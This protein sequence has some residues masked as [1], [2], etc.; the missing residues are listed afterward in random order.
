[1]P[2]QFANISKVNGTGDDLELP[3]YGLEIVLA[4]T[5]GFSIDNKLGEGGFG[6]VYKVT[7]STYL[8][9]KTVQSCPEQLAELLL[10]EPS[11]F[12]EG[13]CWLLAGYTAIVHCRF[14]FSSRFLSVSPYSP[15]IVHPSLKL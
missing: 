14:L 8:I 5:D 12:K 2:L 10:V 9:F 13:N 15:I 6:P 4:A 1:M 7:I 11:M 3:I